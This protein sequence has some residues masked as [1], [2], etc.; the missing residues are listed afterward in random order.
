MADRIF[1]AIRRIRLHRFHPDQGRSCYWQSLIFGRRVRSGT[2]WHPD[3][4]NYWWE[5]SRCGAGDSSL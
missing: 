2:S 5:C 4:T 1:A 3:G